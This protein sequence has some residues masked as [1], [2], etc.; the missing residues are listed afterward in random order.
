MIV[1]WLCSSIRRRIWRRGSGVERDDVRDGAGREE[2]AFEGV[3]G[4]GGGHFDTD[5]TKSVIV[6]IRTHFPVFG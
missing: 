1:A 2:G 4:D 3:V 6:E 5:H